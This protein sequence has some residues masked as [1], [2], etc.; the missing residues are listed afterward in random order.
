MEKNARQT[1]YEILFR[2][3]KNG[4]YSNLL[5][6]ELLKTT[7]SDA[8]NSAFVSAL[9]YGTVER[10][11]TLDYALSLYLSKPIKKLKQEVLTIMRMGA[12]QIFFMDKVP[13]SAAVN[14]SVKLAKK[15]KS[16]YAASLIN[17][18]LRKC[19][20]NGLV[21]PDEKSEDYLS[22]RYSCPGWL[23][24]KWTH[25]YGK[26]NTEE[27]LKASVGKAETIIRVNTLR[28]DEATLKK[29]LTEQGVVCESGYAPNSLKISLSGKEITK[30]P[31]FCDGLFHVQDTASQLC[32]VAL[33]AK[34]GETVFDLC[35]AP[36]GKSFTIAENMNNC[37]KVLSFDL[38]AQ[39]AEL[40]AKGA[41][42]LGIDII[43]AQSGDASEFNEQIGLADKVLCDV[44]CSGL[45]IIRR[46]PEIKY[47][48]Q[49][50]LG[51][52][53]EI[54]LKILKNGARYVKKGGRLVYSTCTLSKAENE[55]VCLAFLKDYADFYPIKPLEKIS[56][57]NFVT[58]MPHKNNSDGFFVAAFERKKEE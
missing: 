20:A 28:T 49:E 35:A 48:T 47:K 7:K 38:Y 4:A 58:L 6:D 26:E 56:D 14:E 27:L 19:A 57:E 15:N 41:K 11:I 51:G 21:Y 39:R 40:I 54:Q 29:I 53:P 2:I 55:E 33:G 34:S 16:N 25:E 31:A 30:L 46:K 13:E 23:I 8:R 50:S 9:V 12:Y 24:H 43:T 10:K 45:G 36:G 52:L 3:E 18:V 44:P 32:A 37:G 5:L 1:A 17:A 22:V 42:R